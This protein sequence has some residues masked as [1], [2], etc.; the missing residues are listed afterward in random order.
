MLS[1]ELLLTGLLLLAGWFWW[2]GLRKRELAVRA[3]GAICQ[4]AGVQFLDDSVAL[5]RIR[6]SRDGRQQMRVY[7]EFAFEYSDTGDNRLPGRVHVLGDQI[8]DVNLILPA[9]DR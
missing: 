2:D 6:L 7:R 9:G 5:S 4:R 3:A 1:W 8:V